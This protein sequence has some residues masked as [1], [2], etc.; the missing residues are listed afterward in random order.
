MCVCVHVHA[1]AH[2]CVCGVIVVVGVDRCIPLTMLADVC[3]WSWLL[4]CVCLMLFKTLSL[5]SNCVSIESEYE[6]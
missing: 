5:F 2:R 6:L 1:H 3:Q 4:M